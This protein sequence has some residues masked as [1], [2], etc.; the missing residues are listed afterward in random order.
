MTPVSHAGFGEF[1]PLAPYKSNY[2][3]AYGSQTANGR[4]P[5]CYLVRALQQGMVFESPDFRRKHDKKTHGSYAALAAARGRNPRADC[6]G[7]SNPSR[8][9]T[10]NLGVVPFG[11]VRFLS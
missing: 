3:T 2:A 1:D 11:N 7:G 5:G 6:I 10:H 8:S 4:G 9:T